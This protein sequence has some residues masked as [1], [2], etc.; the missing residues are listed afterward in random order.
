[1]LDSKLTWTVRF[2]GLEAFTFEGSAFEVAKKISSIDAY[3]DLATAKFEDGTVLY[4][5]GGCERGFYEL[6]CKP[7]NKTETWV[8][9]IS[10]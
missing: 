8:G 5:D 10:L 7:V 2:F 6:F 4:L 1:M 3:F 9:R